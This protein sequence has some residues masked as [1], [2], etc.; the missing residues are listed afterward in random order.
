MG[1]AR[2]PD[3]LEVCSLP[4]VAYPFVPNKHPGRVQFLS[5]LGNS[6]HWQHLGIAT[7]CSSKKQKPWHGNS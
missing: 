6:P 4:V 5:A 1:G 3:S 2:S 7:F